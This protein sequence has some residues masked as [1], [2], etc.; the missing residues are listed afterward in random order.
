MAWYTWSAGDTL[1]AASL[2][3]NFSVLSSSVNAI[4]AGQIEDDAVTAGIIIADAV[5]EQHLNWGD[6]ADSPGAMQ[7][8]K[9]TNTYQR[10]HVKGTV[11]V[12][13]TTLT[14]RTVTATFDD[15]II[16]TAGGVVFAATPVINWHLNTNDTLISVYMIGADTEEA[17]F[18]V[19]HATSIATAQV[20]YWEAVGD[21]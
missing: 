13:A 3:N 2:V 20:L 19:Y 1:S 5:G 12:G 10:M 16:L 14:Y 9:K 15:D 17:E 21:V 6:A 11:A 8:G 4:T 7:I 18:L